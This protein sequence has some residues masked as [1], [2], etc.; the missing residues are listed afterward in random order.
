MVA[1]DVTLAPADSATPGPD[2]RQMVRAELLGSHTHKTTNGIRVHVWCRQGRFLARGRHQGRP[3]GKT[4]SADPQTASAQFRQL[5]VEIENRMFLAPSVA[6]RRPLKLGPPAALTV[7]QLV[8]SYLQLVR[9]L[10]GKQTVGDYFSRLMP[11]IEFSERADSLRRWR[12][13]ADIDGSMDYALGLRSFLFQR[14]VTPN[15]HPIA[16]PKRMS[17]RQIHNVMST[18]SAMFNY[19]K[20]PDVNLLP[21]TFANP[22]TRQIIG[23]KPVRDPLEAPKL[24][25]DLRI[26]MVGL[27]DPWQ[28]ANLAWSF[29]LPQR[30]DEFTALLIQDIDT[31]KRELR[32]GDR[33]GGD[34]HNKAK[35]AF[36]VCYPSE[37]VQLVK[38]LIGTRTAGPLMRRRTIVEGRRQ[39]RSRAETIEEISILFDQAIAKATPDAVQNEQDR[40]RIFRGVLLDLGGVTGE[41]LAGEFKTLLVATGR[42]V[43]ARFYDSRAA[44]ITGLREARVSEI[45]RRYICGRSQG[46]DSHVYYEAQ[47]LHGDMNRYFQHVRPLVEAIATRANALRMHPATNSAPSIVL[48][49]VMRP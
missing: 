5:L 9:K 30:P 10:R 17:A 29:V 35:T 2:G 48:P 24:S 22:I 34:D 40:K 37:F 27:M 33:W 47:D 15:G 11:V 46:R 45:L 16:Q 18:A 44:V 6:R 38:W 14:T 13:A 23:D 25:L 26:Q 43:Q 4:L 20:R 21:S 28:L 36:R 1:M 19:A 12:N 42:P 41:D 8:D 49:E 31:T 39:P 7:R 32:F 3:F